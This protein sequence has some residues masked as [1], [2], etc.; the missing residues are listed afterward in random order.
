MEIQTVTDTIC[1]AA[2]ICKIIQCMFNTK[3]VLDK[4]C[5]SLINM[6]IEINF[7]NDWCD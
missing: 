4:K 5:I 6:Y 7:E 1:W 3:L 2:G